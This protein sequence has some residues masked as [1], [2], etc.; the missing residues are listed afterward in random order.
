MFKVVRLLIFGLLVCHAAYSQTKKPNII[1][2]L[3]DDLGY[4]DVGAYGGE[5][6]TPN[7]DKM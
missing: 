3:D 6:H 2:I 1:F 7:L 5:I 4:S